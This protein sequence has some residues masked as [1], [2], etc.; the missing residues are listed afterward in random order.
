MHKFCSTFT[1]QIGSE[2]KKFF[3]VRVL[4][5]LYFEVSLKWKTEDRRRKGTQIQNK[6]DDISNIRHLE[7]SKYVSHITFDG[8]FK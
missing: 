5:D 3:E 1:N 7:A 4:F 2:S 8:V 6:V